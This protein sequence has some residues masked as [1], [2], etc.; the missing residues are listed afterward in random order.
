MFKPNIKETSQAL[1]CVI[2]TE[3]DIKNACDELFSKLNV[4]NVLLTLGA[5][6]MALVESD[7]SYSHVSTK[8]RKVADVS[9]AGDTVIATLTAALVG[10]AEPKEAASI[11][12]YAA[13]IVCE[14]VGIIPID[15]NRLIEEIKIREGYA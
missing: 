9:G 7:G 14:E 12:N 11:A 8:T 5:N 3:T 1:T 10:G 4:K 15:V 2:Q 13:G 6:G